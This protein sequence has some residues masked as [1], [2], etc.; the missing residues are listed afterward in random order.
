[1]G[2][3]REI[4]RDEPVRTLVARSEGASL[5]VVGSRGSGGFTGLHVGSTALRLMG[6]SH[7]P[8]LFSR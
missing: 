8:I 5:L 6:R 7:C 3:T 1:M 4:V 2:V